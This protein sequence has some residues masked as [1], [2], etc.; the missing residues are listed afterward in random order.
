MT[1]NSKA[2]DVISKSYLQR[3]NLILLVLR[4]WL[5]QLIVHY[6]ELKATFISLN[7]YTI[8]LLQLVLYMIPLNSIYQPLLFTQTKPLRA[9]S[10]KFPR[11]HQSGVGRSKI[12]TEYSVHSKQFNTESSG[13]SAF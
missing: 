2:S 6:G 11:V 8:E 4:S 5:K 12:S 3:S 7:A 10:T 1:V 9:A 13:G